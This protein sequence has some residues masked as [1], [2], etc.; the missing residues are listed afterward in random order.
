MN[1]EKEF[2]FWSKDKSEMSS[3]FCLHEMGN[4]QLQDELNRGELEIV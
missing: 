3:V 4:E 1:I 2:R